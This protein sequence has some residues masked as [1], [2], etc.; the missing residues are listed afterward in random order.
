MHGC[1]AVLADGPIAGC[2][3]T[4]GAGEHAVRHGLAEWFGTRVADVVLVGRATA[5][6]EQP[7]L[8]V[9]VARRL[10]R[11]LEP[12]AAGSSGCRWWSSPAA[13]RTSSPARSRHPGGVRTGVLARR[14]WPEWADGAEP[15]SRPRRSGEPETPA[16]LL[17]PRR[18]LLEFN[19]R[20]LALAEDDRTPLLERLRY[21]AIVSA[22]LDEFY[23]SSG[24]ETAEAQARELSGPA[25]GRD[26]PMPRP[27]W[28][29]TATA[30]DGGP[31]CADAIARRSGRGSGGSSSPRSLRAPSP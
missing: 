4:P 10:R 27:A 7:S 16:D 24:R 21:L 1:V 30:C 17:D 20:V 12:R 23:M 9:W 13:V 28:R 22:N 8:E 18:S 2:P 5:S 6:I 31:T 11:G 26:R 3:V 14:W 19:S 25:A 29:S 15:A